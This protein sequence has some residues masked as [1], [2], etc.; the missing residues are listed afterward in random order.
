MHCR[1]ES[2]TAL[3]IGLAALLLAPGALAAQGSRGGTPIQ[4]GES[5]PPG[6][7]EVR[8]QSCRAPEFEPP[9]IVDYRPRSTLVTEENPVPRAK[10]PVVDVHGHARSLAE[11]GVID[12]MVWRSSTR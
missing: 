6:M 10:Y 12:E 2:L 4:P 7:T 1:R 3:G 5:C 9:S 11:P 8:P